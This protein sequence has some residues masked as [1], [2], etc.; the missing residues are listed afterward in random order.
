MPRQTDQSKNEALFTYVR[1][2]IGQE[3]LDPLISNHIDIEHHKGLMNIPYFCVFNKVTQALY[4]QI[5]EAVKDFLNGSSPKFD[6]ITY[7]K[8]F[9]SGFISEEQLD[10]CRK[11]DELPHVFLSKKTNPI[12]RSLMAVFKGSLGYSDKVIIS[13]VKAVRN[14]SEKSF[15][16]L[17]E[18]STGFE[19]DDEEIL[20]SYLFGPKKLSARKLDAAQKKISTAEDVTESE[21]DDEDSA[22]SSGSSSDGAGDP[23]LLLLDLLQPRREPL[24]VPDRK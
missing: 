2:D 23:S 20:N 24:V 11:P 10:A 7:L 16:S 6:K 1:N 14:L 19:D 15:T 22:S 5:I 13:F 9:V 4:A 18:F 8:I 12:A 3:R 21:D 17:C